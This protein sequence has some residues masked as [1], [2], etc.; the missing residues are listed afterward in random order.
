MRTMELFGARDRL[1]RP[2]LAVNAP[3][4]PV[5]AA[6][7]GCALEQEPAAWKAPSS[8]R[9]R[10][11]APAHSLLGRSSAKL[12]LRAHNRMVGADAC[13]WP[14]PWSW[15]AMMLKSIVASGAFSKPWRLGWLMHFPV[16]RRRASWP[17]VLSLQVPPEF[18]SVSSRGCEWSVKRDRHRSRRKPPLT[19]FSTASLSRQSHE[20]VR[21]QRV[22][23]SRPN[24]LE[25]KDAMSAIQIVCAVAV[26]LL[27][28]YQFVAIKV[29]V[30]EFPPLFFLALR[31][32]AIALLLIPFVKRPTRQQFGLI[33]A[34]SV[35]LG[36]LNFGLFY[37]GLGLGS[38]SMSA[39]AYQLATPFTVL[40]A[41]PLLAERPSLTTSAGV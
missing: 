24:G 13:W 7:H 37:V 15:L 10:S 9:G 11:S 36:G 27:W 2:E 33:A 19:R 30:M 20:R 23:I 34:I 4:V 22:S 41:W 8:C 18:S 35:F 21:R 38:G 16:R 12:G 5:T 31:F 39:V 25:R 1:R 28:G 17:M 3:S 40:L 14:Q 6:E 26:P 29:G 32:L